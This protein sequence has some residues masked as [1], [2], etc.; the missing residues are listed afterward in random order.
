MARA[1]SDTAILDLDSFHNENRPAR[2]TR[3]ITL[4][5]AYVLLLTF[6]PSSLVLGALGGAGSPARVFAFTLLSWYVLLWLHPGFALHRG[7]QPARLAAAFFAFVYVAA[8]VSANR[9]TLDST[10]QNG[11]DRGMIFVTGWLAVLLLAADGIETWDQLQVLLRRLVTCISV[12]AAIGITQFA[13]GFNLATF[14][15]IPGLT[16]QIAFVD[17]LTRDGINRPS[18]TTAH[19]L[20]FAAVLGLALPLGAAPGPVRQARRPVPA[21]A[22]GGPDRHRTSAHGLPLRGAGA[23]DHRLR[24]HADLASPP[25]PD[26]LPGAAREGWLRSG[27]SQPRLISLIY[28][29]FSETGSE[30]SSVSRL[31]AYSAAGPFIA[32]H[33]WL[34]AGV[35]D[36]PAPDVLLRQRPVPDDTDRD[37]R[38]GLDHRPDAVPPR[39]VPRPGAPA[40]SAW[41]SRLVTSCSASPC[42]RCAPRCHSPRSTRWATRLSQA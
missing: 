13:T 36:L 12:I 18:A 26:H 35:R 14:V 32:Q 34:G 19:R 16:R 2:A 41:T 33:P 4:L 39:L 24:A 20:E 31:D 3:A 21:L 30:S 5:T 11:A 25:A 40:G 22:A 27:W 38:A 9:H 7:R 8:Y 28:Q 42:Q 6:I 1:W 10:A 17:L 29:L 15:V 37:R 23:G